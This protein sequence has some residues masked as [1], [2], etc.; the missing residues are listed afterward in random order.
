MIQAKADNII[1]GWKAM[2]AV[3]SCAASENNGK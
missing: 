1:S 3:L 2:F